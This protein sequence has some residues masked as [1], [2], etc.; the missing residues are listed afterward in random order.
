LLN[1]LR[2]LYKDDKATFK[3]I[4]QAEASKVVLRRKEHLLAI[5]PTGGGKSLLWQLPIFLEKDVTSVVILP[6][7]VLVEQVEAQ[8]IKLGLS[9]QVWENDGIDDR[10][11]QVL[12]VAVEHAIMLEFQTLLVQLE[13]TN[14]LA[15]L[16][17][18]EC[19]TLVTHKEFR[20]AVR[21]LGGTI[22]S[23]NAQVVLLTATIPPQLEDEVRVTFGC[24]DWKVIRR[25][26]DRP[27]LN[28][29][30]FDARPIAS[31]KKEFDHKFCSLVKQVCERFG[32]AD[33]GIVY[34]LQTTWA[35]EVA[36]YLNKAIRQDFCLPYH[37]KMSKEDRTAAIEAWKRGDVLFLIATSALG[38]GLDYGSVK[39]I[40]HHVR[41]KNLIEFV[42]ETG[43]AGRNGSSAMCLTVYWDQLD[44]QLEWIPEEERQAMTDWI[45]SDLCRKKLLSIAMHGQ[46]EE[47]LRQKAGK[48]CDNCKKVLDGK[49][50]MEVKKAAPLKRRREAETMEV[51][52]AVQVKRMLSDLKGKCSWCW[53][54]G[55]AHAIDH[56]LQRCRYRSMFMDADGQQYV[57]Q[58]SYMS[59]H[60]AQHEAMQ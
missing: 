23:V 1:G 57:W 37:A 7:V 21:K 55:D 36:K 43:R 4:E 3:S 44:D 52:E 26:E 8:C 56:P 59:E 50:P 20:P 27:E 9:Y 15:R 22:R 38:A 42:Q 16:V 45:E 10:I 19:H 25:I 6:Y 17:I 35:E 58:M 60:G 46:G 11:P 49:P 33:R 28:Y 47:C 29:Q 30:V 24:S 34:C 40:V 51:R 18:D 32:P 13:S 31:T 5:L 2:K 41:G 54:W 53:V 12:I 48:F 39:A 14:T